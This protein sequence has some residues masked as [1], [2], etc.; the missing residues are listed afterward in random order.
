MFPLGYKGE[1]I[2]KI[3][4][5]LGMNLFRKWL[6]KFVYRY[7]YAHG[8]TDEIAAPNGKRWNNDPDYSTLYFGW[9]DGY[10]RVDLYIGGNDLVATHSFE[11]W[12]EY[13]VFA[14]DQDD[15][16]LP[17]Q[18]VEFY[19]RIDEELLA[20]GM[21]QRT[22]IRQCEAGITTKYAGITCTSRLQVCQSLHNHW[23]K[24]RP[25]RRDTSDPNWVCADCF[26]TL[27][28]P[29]VQAV[30]KPIGIQA[31]RHKLSKTMRFEVMQRDGFS[32]RACGRNARTDG[33]K[34]HVDHIKPILHG[35]LTVIENLQTLCED[36]NLGKSAKLVDQ[37]DNW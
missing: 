33:V 16:F 35:G 24:N 20:L 34:L 14:R 17:A 28:S 26:T 2:A 3:D 36:C 9:D 23:A 31:E 27:T 37:M 12:N 22:A 25:T 1:E 6:M 10:G 7:G 29:P 13:R 30:N 21:N 32:C 15:Q 5:A 19:Q 8:R 4:L 11:K 18:L